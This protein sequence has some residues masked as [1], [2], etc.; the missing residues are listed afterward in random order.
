MESNRENPGILLTREVLGLVLLIAL[1][2]VP[3]AKAA[4]SAVNRA[5]A[6]VSGEAMEAAAGSNQ[7]GKFYPGECS[8]PRNLF[9]GSDWEDQRENYDR[10]NAEIERCKGGIAFV[11]PVGDGNDWRVIC[12]RESKGEYVMTIPEAIRNG[13]KKYTVYN[14]TGK[15]SIFALD[16][17][18][19]SASTAQSAAYFS[20]V[21]TE[22]ATVNFEVS[23]CKTLSSNPADYRSQKTPQAFLISDA[24]EDCDKIAKKTDIQDSQKRLINRKVLA[25]LIQCRR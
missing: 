5:P 9:T 7:G 14:K 16:R 15:G 1:S 2:G 4:E 23:G 11:F 19:E 10:T 12:S 20:S 18:P 25:P 8:Y 21:C 17:L 13:G 6:V 3:A 24:A 22:N